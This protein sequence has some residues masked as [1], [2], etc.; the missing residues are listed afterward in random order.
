MSHSWQI[1]FI[2]S[3]DGRDLSSWSRTRSCSE[4]GYSCTRPTRFTWYFI[5]L[6]PADA[7]SLYRYQALQPLGIAARYIPFTKRN[8]SCHVF[9]H[10]LISMDTWSSVFFCNSHHLNLSGA[11]SNDTENARLKRRI[12]ELESNLMVSENEIHR[13]RSLLDNERRCAYFSALYIGE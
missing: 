1:F 9:R 8:A 13:L 12:S 4:C 7:I 11:A 2:F 10:L 5:V 3:Y 6:D